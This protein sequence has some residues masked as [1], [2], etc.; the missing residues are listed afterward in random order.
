M[1]VA[2]NGPHALQHL[3]RL[4]APRAAVAPRDPGVRVARARLLGGSRRGL[5]HEPLRR[6][7]IDEERGLVRERR[8]AHGPLQAAGPVRLGPEGD[9]RARALRRE[10]RA[11]L[12]LYSCSKRNCISSKSF[13]S[14]SR[15]ASLYVAH[16]SVSHQDFPELMPPFSKMKIGARGLSLTSAAI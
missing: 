8:L 14:I 6:L 2:E 11:E 13:L 4:P 16:T 5:V 1:E 10:R 3:L 9:L 7:R 15:A 12:F